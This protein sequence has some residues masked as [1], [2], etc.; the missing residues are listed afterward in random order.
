MGG[1]PRS[2][3]GDVVLCDCQMY[4]ILVDLTKMFKIDIALER[5]DFLC[6]QLTVNNPARY[7]NHIITINVIFVIISENCSCQHY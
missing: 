1:R 4:R 6:T 2:S 5:Q 3:F 7:D